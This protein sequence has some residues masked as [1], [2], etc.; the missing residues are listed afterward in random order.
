MQPAND[1]MSMADLKACLK[2]QY[3][4]LRLDDE[5]AVRAIPRLLPD[6]EQARRSAFDAL[7]EVLGARGALPEEGA[8]RLNRVE[9]LFGLGS[10][11]SVLGV[12]HA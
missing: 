7:L 9:T 8:R 11:A 10:A 12:S 5:R 3:L 6:S 2:E 1:R 4:L